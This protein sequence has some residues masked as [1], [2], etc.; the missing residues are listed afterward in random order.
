MVMS[1]LAS[2]DGDWQRGN[3]EPEEIGRY[4]CVTNGYNFVVR[5]RR[6]EERGEADEGKPG[7]SRT[8]WKL[9]RVEI[10]RVEA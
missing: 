2:G 8:D 1:S 6:K 9:G 10:D 5:S 7:R 4:L 3:D